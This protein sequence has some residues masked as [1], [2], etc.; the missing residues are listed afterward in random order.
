MFELFTKGEITL[1]WEIYPDVVRYRYIPLGITIDEDDL[2]AYK[3]QKAW[4]RCIS[5]PSYAVCKNRIKN[6]FINLSNESS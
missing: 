4:R 6:E 5:D 1:A 2:M 3:I